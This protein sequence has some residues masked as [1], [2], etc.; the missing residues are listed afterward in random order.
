M[1]KLLHAI[2]LGDAY[3]VNARIL[4]ATLAVLPVTT[5]ALGMEL[6]GGHWARAIG[7]GAGL[8]VILAVAFSKLAHAFG[9]SLE[10]KLIARWGGLPTTIWLLPNDPAH[11]MQQKHIWRNALAKLSG[12]DLETVI[13]TNDVD[14]LTRILNDAV[15][16]VRNKIRHDKR[17]ALLRQHNIYYGFARNLSGLKWVTLGLT[18]FSVVAALIA[19]RQQMLPVPVVLIE[20]LFLTVAAS[21]VTISERYVRHCAERYAEFFLTN[22]VT[23]AKSTRASRP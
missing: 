6:H 17:V 11:S 14:E 4:P 7:L 13:A 16:S 12:L 15:L 5:L 8:E 22:V 2:N 20:F 21:F 18:T 1:Q 23:I 19:V 3:E 10:R 9:Q